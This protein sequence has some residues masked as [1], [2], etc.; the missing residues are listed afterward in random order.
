MSLALLVVLGRHS[1]EDALRCL[2]LLRRQRVELLLAWLNHRE[3]AVKHS[4]RY[5][6]LLLTQILLLEHE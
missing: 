6:S 2:H 5:V 3:V 4:T 1:V